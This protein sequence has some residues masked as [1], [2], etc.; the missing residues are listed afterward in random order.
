MKRA[1]IAILT[2]IIMAISINPIRARAASEDDL[3]AYINS[4]RTQAGLG[5]LSLDEELTGVALTRASESSVNF[6]HVRPNG[7]AWYTVSSLT[8]GENLAHARND[9][10]K[11]PENVMLAFLLSPT[12]K[13]NVMRSSFTV[14]GIAYYV[15]A[16]GDTYIACE[17]R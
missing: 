9:N 1:L 12:H 3:L 15:G 16:N 8:N 13:A 5:A 2:V 7:T 10:Q 11:K 17:F 6:S 14:V 4:A